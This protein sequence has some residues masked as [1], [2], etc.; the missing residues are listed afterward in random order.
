MDLHPALESEVNRFKRPRAFGASDS[1]NATRPLITLFDHARTTFF[2][3][4]VL[5]TF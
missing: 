5:F 1:N 3:A 4:F 2:Q